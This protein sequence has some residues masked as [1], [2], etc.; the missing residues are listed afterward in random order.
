ML[1]CE[2]AQ[3]LSIS[4]KGQ[5][6]DDWTIGNHR[7]LMVILSISIVYPLRITDKIQYTLFVF[8]FQGKLKQ[9][10]KYPLQRIKEN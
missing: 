9:M 1:I 5:N 2:L 8:V 6:I 10:V 7:G 3:V 4:E